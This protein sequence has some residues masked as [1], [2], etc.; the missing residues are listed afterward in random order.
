[1]KS[2]IA[3]I[4]I[5]LLFFC[6]SYSL[7]NTVRPSIEQ[8]L[9]DAEKHR[10]QDPQKFS[11][12][13]TE[14]EAISDKL[15][16]EQQSQFSLLKAYNSFMTGDYQQPEKLLNFALTNSSDKATR[17]RAQYGLI[18]LT[19]AKKD[20]ATG[21]QYIE[22]TLKLTDALSSINDKEIQQQIKLAK[23]VVIVFF[24]QLQQFDLALKHL[25][26]L[27]RDTLNLK[28]Q[29]HFSQ[30][31]IEANQ[32]LINSPAFETYQIEQALKLCENANWPVAVSVVRTYLA[33]EHLTQGNLQQAIFTIMPHIEA[34]KATRFSLA[35]IEAYNI[36]ANAYFQLGNKV[37]SE[38]YADLAIANITYNSTKQTV[39]AYKIKY[40]LAFDRDD[41]KNALKFYIQYAEADKAYLND[42]SAKNVAFQLAQ[43]K[44]AQQKS[45]IALLNKENELLNNQ[46]RLLN[47]EQNL[48]KTEAEN[49][50]LVAA[51]FLAIIALLSFF[52]YRSWRTQKRLKTLAEYDFLTKVYNRGHFMT[53]AEDTVSLAEKSGQTVTCIIL[54]LD[55]FKKI[56]DSYG[57]G[58]GDWALI[59]TAKAI[60]SCIRD[61][62]IF[63]RLGGE[64]FV[65]M[66]PSCDIQAA[67]YVSEK[68]I[69]TLQQIDTKESGHKFQ[70]TASFGITTTKLSGYDV[71]ALIADADKALY[72]AKD[73]GRNQFTIYDNT[74]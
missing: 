20:W 66:L 57:H 49:T 25:D 4:F 72:Q 38:Q 22:D 53:L 26:S 65:I 2:F 51:L 27:D 56:N 10:Q 60:K 8:L 40:Q 7:A 74:L 39:E 36:L 11:E 28:E 15:T 12:L 59:A 34:I 9:A 44:T 35:I 47:T 29:C 55:K 48:V 68:C 45:E 70:I 32:N 3:T 73:G 62:D 71:G 46:N 41:F 64:E 17:L 1:M 54:D 23:F 6:T 19:I 61:H 50:R 52:G 21:F 42:V 24:N 18:N 13:L 14:L 30:Q 63:A 37:K 43:H 69:S 67:T 33:K 58:A 31:K 5:L 16:L